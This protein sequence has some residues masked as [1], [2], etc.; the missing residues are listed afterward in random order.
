MPVSPEILGERLRAARANVDLT[1]EQVA[2]AVGMQRTAL[3]QVEAGNRALSSVELF[4]L[5]KLYGREMSDFLSEKPMEEDPLILLRSIA[6]DSPELRL[7]I[8][9]CSEMLREATKL[10]SYLGEQARSFPPM[11]IYSDPLTYK[12]AIDQGKEIAILERRRLDLGSAPVLDVAYV[13]MSQTMWA[14]AA[15]FRDEVS[16]IFLHHPDYGLAVVVN[17]DHPPVRR[18][19]SYAHEYAHALSDRQRKPRPSS[20]QNAHDLIEKRA[21]AFASEF[22]MPE[23]GI[24]ESLERLRKGA[25]S[26]EY[27]F[28]YDPITDEAQQH[29]S[30]LDANAQRITV[31]E[32]AILA[33]EFKVSYD[34]AV[35]RLSD[36]GAIR[37]PLVDEL[38][39]RR[40]E[41]RIL[42]EQLK[43]YNGEEDRE[44]QPYL[45]RQLVLL[46]IEAFRRDKITTGR[47][48]SICKMAGYPADATDK[49]M[50]VAEALASE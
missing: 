15:S 4:K 7:E 20:K 5:A 40:Q 17:Q 33:H 11:Y 44:D 26:R 38:I 35:Y 21:N 14:A 6:E 49:L 18:R 22:L 13:I 48:R 25:S 29:E 42:I 41:G 24:L 50:K 10:Q 19:F 1:Q 36:I 31:R 47:F 27:S 8:A 30:R 32:V 45:Q 16:G 9:K 23:T 3:V 34:V 46:A 43:L 37:K 39:D 12:Q 28:M 2:S